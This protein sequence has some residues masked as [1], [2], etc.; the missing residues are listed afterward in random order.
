M[1]RSL[2]VAVTFL[3]LFTMA[4]GSAAVGNLQTARVE[5]SVTVARPARVP[6]S[7]VSVSAYP[8]GPRIIWAD[9][10]QT[11]S[12]TEQGVEISRDAGRT[13]TDVT[14]R[15]LRTAVEDRSISDLFP[16]DAFRAWVAFGGSY[17]QSI[18]TLASTSDGGR[19]WTV[20]GHAPSPGCQIQFVTPRVG[21]CPVIGAAAGS[22]S[23]YLYRTADGGRHWSLIS[24]TPIFSHP[25]GA[26][27]YACDKKIAFTGVNVGWALLYCNGGLASLYETSDGGALWIRRQIAPPA[28][29]FAYGGFTGI[30]K[31]NGKKGAVGYTFSM[32]NGLLRTAVYVTGDAGTSWRAVVPPGGV[33][34]WAVDALTASDWLLVSGSIVL[35]T[36]TAGKRWS[37]IKSNISF[38]PQDISYAYNLS[39]TPVAFVNDEIGW[40]VSSS[41]ETGALLWRTSDGG[42]NWKRVVV[43]GE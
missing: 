28:F 3:G 22:S 37:A 6:A 39:W 13:W 14:P 5:P 41:P 9:W 4:P 8:I 31:L 36:T 32:A 42:L 23:V 38:N 19:R 30:P 15:W 7:D 2:A 10:A 35:T 1:S 16:L 17:S 40:I 34:L 21:W 20:V 26:L 29:S 11:S 18:Q 12:G 27:P 25:K 33:R 43:P 24:R